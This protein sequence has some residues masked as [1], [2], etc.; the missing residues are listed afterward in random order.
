[1]KPQKVL[2]TGVNGLL[3]QNLVKALKGACEVSGLDLMEKP[4]IPDG[5]TAYSRVDI[6]KQEEL[7]AFFSKHQPDTVIN[8]A[9]VT[10]VDLC[11][12]EQ[13]KADLVNHRAVRLLLTTA[14]KKVRFVQL[15]TDYVFDGESGPYGD[16]DKPNPVSVYGLTKFKAEKAVMSFSKDNLVIRTMVLFGK[17]VNVRPDFITFLKSSLSS[18]KAVNVVTDQIG[19]ITLANNLARN[20]GALIKEGITGVLAV[21]GL[22]IL[23]RHEIAFKVAEHYGLDASL[24]RPAKTADLK[25]A[26]RRPLNSGF[27]LERARKVPGAELIDFKEQLRRYDVE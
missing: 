21:S 12:K 14:G 3:G 1:M 24:I 15:S 6:T 11:E 8:T 9:A 26:A 27:R 17:A 20:M 25:Q 4:V 23:S 5:L 22:D 18:G 19:N 2:I 16:D 10:N 13:E 7:R